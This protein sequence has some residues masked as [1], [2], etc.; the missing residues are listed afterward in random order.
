VSDLEHPERPAGLPERRDR[1]QRPWPAWAAI[2]IALTA[3]VGGGIFAVI[4]IAIHNG[5]VDL[6]VH[7]PGSV[8][9]ALHGAPPLVTFIGTMAQ[10]LILIAG[11]IYVV[12]SST[13]PGRRASALGLR[14]ARVASSAGFVLLGYV[15]FI[16]ISAVWVSALGIKDHE[17]VAIQ[18]GTR[19]SALALAGGALITCVVAPVCEEL[20]FRGFLF[21]ALRKR[22]LVVAA[23]VTGVTFG[24]VHVGSAPI[25]FLVPLAVLGVILCLIYERTGSLYPC[26]ALHA[27]NNSIAFGVGD[28]R[29]WLIPVGLAMAAAGIFGLSR[30]TPATA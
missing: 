7:Q 27:F 4:A 16:V 6:P 15:V 9:V 18:L 11:A 13:P 5:L 24:L 12:W 8:G 26:M 25:G 3:F 1:V 20:F 29:G 28:G 22:G 21:G 14:P 10:D 23:L 19:D 2:P 17:S 30:F